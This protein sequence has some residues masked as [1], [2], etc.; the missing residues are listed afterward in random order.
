MHI[1]SLHRLRQPC[2]L[3]AMRKGNA[4][5]AGLLLALA[6]FAITPLHAAVRNAHKQATY[7]N[8]VTAGGHPI[9]MGDPFAF[10]A[11]GEYLL[12]GTTSESEG[13]QMYRSPD[14][15]HG[16]YIGWL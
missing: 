5:R 1:F 7:T 6:A 12:T 13:F 3:V 14:L 2:S 11:D 9:H 8:P 4:I 16:K 15:V 10:R